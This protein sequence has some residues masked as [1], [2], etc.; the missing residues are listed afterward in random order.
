MSDFPQPKFRKGQRVYHATTNSET[1]TLP[2][3]DCL[4]SRRWRVITP[5][6]SELEAECQRC[7]NYGWSDLPSLKRITWKP[8]VSPLTIGSIRIDTAAHRDD[9]PVSYMCEETGVGS[10]NV[11]YEKQLFATHEEATAHATTEAAARVQVEDA[12]PARIEQKTLSALRFKDAIIEQAR[13]SIWSAWYRYRQLREDIEGEI[14]D[15]GAYKIEDLKDGIQQHLDWDGKHRTERHVIDRL[16]EA[17][18]AVV[19]ERGEPELKAALDAL[20]FTGY[21]ARELATD[22]PLGMER[23]A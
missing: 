17:A 9:S 1:E 3:P 11:Y 18:A 15:G 22:L 20:P 8:Y 7:G 16:I 5:A 4:G 13:S 21:P 12:K 10:G 19:A 6:G 14:K 2:C 23:I